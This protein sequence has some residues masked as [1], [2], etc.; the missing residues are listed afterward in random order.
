MMLALEGVHTF[1]GEAHVL[2]GVSLR[3]ARGAFVTLLG[4]N[5]AGK[6]TTLRSIMGIVPVRRGHIEFDEQDITNLAPEDIARLGLA[7]VPEDRRIFPNLTVQENLRLGVLGGNGTVDRTDAYREVFAYFPVLENNLGRRGGLMSGGEQQML[8]IGRAMVARPSLMLID[9]P[10]EGLSPLLVKAL[11]GALRT[12]N[13]RGTTVLLVEQNL[14]VALALSS[15]LYIID[16][17]EIRFEGTAD[18][19]RHD[20]SVQR[21]LLGV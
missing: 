14:E 8:A 6:S 20:T 21:R 10:T 12:I 1:Y 2:H 13:Q 4:R 17:G 16:Q 11:V 9:E 7:Y 15:A 18:E 3:V 19:L 5:G